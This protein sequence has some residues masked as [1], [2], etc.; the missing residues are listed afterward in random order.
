MC[1][2]ALSGDEIAWVSKLVEMFTFPFFIGAAHLR[3]MQLSLAAALITSL[4]ARKDSGA[5]ESFSEGH[6]WLTVLGRPCHPASIANEQTQGFSLRFIIV[7]MNEFRL[8]LVVVLRILSSH[9]PVNHP[10]PTN[11]PLSADA[12]THRLRNTQ[13]CTGKAHT[14]THPQR[15]RKSDQL[16]KTWRL[17]GK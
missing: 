10:Q 9:Q 15:G 2:C 12:N 16:I 1:T 3:A 4:L 5:T 13:T 6:L 7:T 17:S 11:N 8:L 14:H